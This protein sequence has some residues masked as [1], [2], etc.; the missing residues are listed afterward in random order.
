MDEGIR[1]PI[2]LEGDKAFVMLNDLGGAAEKTGQKLRTI[3]GGANQAQFALVN[4][5]RVVQDAPYGFIGIANNINPLLESFQ[6]L[7]A[8]TGST[9]G[10]LKALI[11]SLTGAGGLGLA[12][13]LATSAMLLFNGTLLGSKQG[14]EEASVSLKQYESA[15]EDIKNAAEGLQSVLNF[16]ESIRFDQY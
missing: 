9:G 2:I 3:G 14:A 11:S 13:S 10:T 15:L 4:L 1:I 7:Q 8:T 6:R 5:G 12:V 16:R